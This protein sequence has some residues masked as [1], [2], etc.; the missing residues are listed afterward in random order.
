[1]KIIIYGAGKKGKAVLN[2]ILK[3]EQKNIDIIG[4]CDQK[5]K[6]KIK[7][8]S[9]F[10]IEE[11]KN[12][13]ETVIIAMEDAEMAIDVSIELKL[14]GFKNIWW[15]N[16]KRKSLYGEFLDRWCLNCEHWDEDVLPQ[17]E[18][19][20]IDSCNLNCRGCT[21]FSPI[22]P[23]ELPDFSSRIQDVKILK[24]KFSYIIEFY[25]LG[26]EPFLNPMV[27]DYIKGIREVLPYS[28]IYIVTNGILIPSINDEILKCIKENNI[29][30]SISE[31]Y[32]THKLIDKICERLDKFDIL[33]EVRNDKSRT[34]FNIPL[35]LN[36]QSVYPR[37]CISKGCVTIWNGKIAKCPTLMYIQRFNEYFH[38]NLP[39]EGIMELSECS[40][41]KKLLEIL[42]KEVP[43]CKHC[44]CNETEWSVCKRE[45]KI[46]DFATDK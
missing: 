42:H 13:E 30:V 37:L 33:Y 45:I 20:I 15:F 16:G 7:G 46:E 25:I 8:Y 4:F 14:K 18:M 34:K 3:D 31:Y 38:V 43:L 12:F 11:L 10:T 41:G 40:S 2:L 5:E 32:P 29:C 35:S 39:D 26:G 28:M 44:V 23:N 1:M 22:F 21:H 9:I 27:A 17:A 36:E 24:E 19:H 6:G